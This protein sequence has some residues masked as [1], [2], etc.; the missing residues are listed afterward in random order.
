MA[1][2]LPFLTEAI[3][4]QPHEQKLHEGVN[5]LTS[6]S[7]RL[8]V[9]ACRA[10]Q[11][12]RP[13]T[14]RPVPPPNV[15][16]NKSRRL[17]RASRGAVITSLLFKVAQKKRLTYSGCAPSRRHPETAINAVF[18]VSY[19]TGEANRRTGATARRDY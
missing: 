6:D 7:F 17:T 10:G 3:M 8:A 12:R 19:G 11:S 18:S 15:S 16:F 14:A 1:T 9:P 2:S 4:P 5:S 13:P